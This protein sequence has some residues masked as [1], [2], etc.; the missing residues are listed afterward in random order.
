MSEFFDSM[1]MDYPRMMVVRCSLLG[2]IYYIFS[3]GIP[4]NYFIQG[5]RNRLL[6]SN[7]PV[8]FFFSISGADLDIGIENPT[9]RSAY[10]HYSSLDFILTEDDHVY[11]VPTA[12]TQEYQEQ[13]WCSA[14]DG[15]QPG[16]LC[17]GNN[18]LEHQYCRDH[19]PENPSAFCDEISMKCDYGVMQQWCI[20]NSSKIIIPVLP[21]ILVTARSIC[22]TDGEPLIFSNNNKEN[23]AEQQFVEI[24]ILDLLSTLSKDS[25]TGLTWITEDS[26]LT[27][28]LLWG[29]EIDIAYNW[30]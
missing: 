26:N 11:F 27:E 7:S 14:H 2:L 18:T 5:V 15:G 8:D 9:N 29:C 28:K 6:H 1:Y 25:K 3:L 21:S 24:D 20:R 22:W 23:P 13:S 10:T 16:I 4:I 19:Y 30:R 17:R 12:I